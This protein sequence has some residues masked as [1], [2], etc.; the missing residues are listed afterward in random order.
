V[1]KV[2]RSLCAV[3][4][5]VVVAFMVQ[6]LVVSSGAQTQQDIDEAREELG[7]AEAEL[8]SARERLD[9][10]R[11]HLAD[12]QTTIADI[13][14]DVRVLARRS[15]KQE[16]AVIHLS[17]ELY[18]GGSTGVIESVLSAESVSDLDKDIKYLQSSE[19][20]HSEELE[21][22]A[23][24]TLLLDRR[25]NELDTAREEAAQVLDDVT[26][27]AAEL[28]AEVA[29]SRGDVADLEDA[30]A[31]RRAEEA[32]AEAAALAEAAREIV[33]PPPPPV[34]VSDSSVNWDAIAQCESGGNWALDSTYDGG[35]QFHPST[36]LGYGGGQYARYA[37]QATREQQIAIAEKVL[38]SQ[39]PGAWP[40]C[41]QYG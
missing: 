9:A 26:A 10:A 20:A 38:A 36:W 39:G 12:L 33:S 15:L 7:A 8:G 30:V 40:H 6:L 18:M 4:G 34:D 41:F 32:A 28:E 23:V 27:L 37:W 21:E 2:G 14:G 35:L 25:L 19:D 1:T 31:A 22:L 16:R 5:L 17:E 29:A 24:D 3:C 11:A 13:E